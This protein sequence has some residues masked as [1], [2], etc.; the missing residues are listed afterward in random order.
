MPYLDKS[1]YLSIC[2]NTSHDSNGKTTSTVAC[3][4]QFTNYFPRHKPINIPSVI[5]RRWAIK[6]YQST[7]ISALAPCSLDRENKKVLFAESR[8]TRTWTSCSSKSSWIVFSDFVVILAV[9]NID[10]SNEWHILPAPQ[11]QPSG[12][13]SDRRSYRDSKKRLGKQAV[14]LQNLSVGR[15]ENWNSRI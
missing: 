6:N 4:G 15:D 9:V 12:Q 2:V 8:K 11:L 13:G 7:Y 10:T 14:N 3:N 5:S 1:C